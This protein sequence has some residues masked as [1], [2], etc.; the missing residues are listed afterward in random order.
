MTDIVVRRRGYPLKLGDISIKKR[1]LSHHCMGVTLNLG[2]AISY[3]QPTNNKEILLLN[4]S[5]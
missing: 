3:I 5:K 2:K 4:L 1:L